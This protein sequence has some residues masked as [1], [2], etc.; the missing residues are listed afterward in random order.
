MKN[1]EK[2][3][4]EIKEAYKVYFI[5]CKEINSVKLPKGILD[6]HGAEYVEAMKILC[7]KIENI[8]KKYSVKVSNKDFSQQEVNKIRK[9]VYNED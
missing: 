4:D 5:R 7:E 3:I 6:G 1:L 8:E 2:A 9:E